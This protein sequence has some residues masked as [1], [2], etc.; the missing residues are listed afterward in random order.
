MFEGSNGSRI[1]DFPNTNGVAC[2]SSANGEPSEIAGGDQGPTAEAIEQH[3]P[4][5]ENHAN[6]LL[7]LLNELRSFANQACDAALRE[8]EWADRIEE[9][10]ETEINGLWEQIKE[11]DESI[12]ARNQALAKLEEASKAKLLELES[13]IQDQEIQLSNREIQAQ[14]LVSEGDYLIHRLKEAE[15]V[16]EEAEAR[17]Q[18]HTACME[19]ELTDLRVQLA[20]RE[21][22]LAVREL[23]LSRYEGDLRTN[24]QNLQLRLQDTEAKLAGREREI[25]Q[26]EALI[27]A[28]ASRETEIGRLIERLSSECEKLSAELCEKRLIFARLQDKRRHSTNGGRMWRKVLDLVQ[29]EAF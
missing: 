2:E 4:D 9:A 21:E 7:D 13:R 23:A 14:Q 18:Q 12:E 19:A 15:L 3:Q 8:A 6:G 5:V 29:E 27:E 26:K 20:K 25:K 16:A 17:V 10:M 28:A 24:I 22:S 1:A 11:K